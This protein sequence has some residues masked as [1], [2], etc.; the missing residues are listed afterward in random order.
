MKSI[1][2]R[3]ERF[4]E[5][6]V[7]PAYNVFKRKVE[8]N[9]K[10]YRS[11]LRNIIISHKSQIDTCE[12]FQSMKHSLL[13]NNLIIGRIQTFGK[14]F[15]AFSFN[16]ILIF[17]CYELWLN[18]Y[19]YLSTK[20]CVDTCIFWANLSFALHCTVYTVEYNKLYNILQYFCWIKSN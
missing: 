11:K 7:E 10:R 18:V 5:N 2:L 19:N 20:N 4:L 15:Y 8:R 17:S 12:N 13:C 9:L 16:K 6:R 14:I 1:R 3:A